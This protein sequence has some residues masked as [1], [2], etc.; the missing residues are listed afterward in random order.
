VTR[1]KKKKG[2]KS[3]GKGIGE[4]AER[5]KT[6][7]QGGINLP[8]KGNERHKKKRGGQKEKL[9]GFGCQKKNAQKWG[10]IGQTF[11]NLQGGGDGENVQKEKKGDTG[12]TI[13]AEKKRV[14]IEGG[15]RTKNPIHRRKNEN[16]DRKRR[17]TP[18][19]KKSL[20]REVVD[21]RAA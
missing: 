15:R 19:E 7:Q 2:G 14:K 18:K 11:D 12:K 8:A 16:R 4:G 5:G 13:T 17:K 1:K 20:L 3:A 6:N 21:G 10:E 9:S